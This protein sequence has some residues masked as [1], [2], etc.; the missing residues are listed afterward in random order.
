MVSL[1]KHLPNGRAWARVWSYISGWLDFQDSQTNK[2]LGLTVIAFLCHERLLP[3]SSKDTTQPIQGFY[4]ADLDALLKGQSLSNK[5]TI[6]ERLAF[7][8]LRVATS[9]G[10]NYIDIIQLF[11]TTLNKEAPLLERFDGLPD[12]YFAARMRFTG[13]QRSNSTPLNHK[14]ACEEVGVLE[15]MEAVPG[16]QAGWLVVQTEDI[17]IVAQEE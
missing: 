2:Q 6:F 17:S 5:R 12:Q 14:S 3:Y 10:D 11:V 4:L 13:E 9:L 7:S 8:F 16:H 15:L 1:W